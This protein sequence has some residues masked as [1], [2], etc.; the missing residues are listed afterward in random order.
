METLAET[1]LPAGLRRTEPSSL[2]PTSPD[3]EQSPQN[4]NPGSV[5]AN[6]IGTSPGGSSSAH[7]LLE[8]HSQSSQEDSGSVVSPVPHPEPEET[9]ENIEKELSE[10]CVDTDSQPPLELGHRK[11]TTATVS[12]RNAQQGAAASTSSPTTSATGGKGNDANGQSAV[13]AGMATAT[14][15]T[16]SSTSVSNGRSLPKVTPSGGKPM[17]MR[18]FDRK[19]NKARG[20]PK[21]KAM[22][23]LYQSEISENKI[24]IKLCIKKA[25]DATV[26]PKKPIRKRARKPKSLNEDSSDET[27]PEK[28]N[29]RSEKPR[30]TNNNT[31]KRSAEEEYK[32]PEDQSVWANEIPDP[33]LYTIF[34][35]VVQDEGSLPTLIRLS[36]VCSSWYK[37]SQ[38][39]SLWR[40]V[41]LGTWAKDRFKTEP[42]LK[43][44]IENRLKQA[45]EVGLANWKVTNVQ[46]VL[47]KLLEAAPGLISI[48]LTGWKALSADHLF[49]LVQNF[50]NLESLDLS[51]INA[52]VNANKTAVGQTSLCNAITEMGSRLTH[53][54]LAHNRLGGIPQIVKALSTHCPNLVLLDLSNVNTVAISHGI[55]HIEQLQHGCQKLKVL[56]ITNSHINLSTASLQEQ[57]E[58]PGFPELEELS[59]ASLAD[60]A[61]LFNDEFLQRI[62]K[63]STKLT[64]LDVRGCAR[65]THDSLIR[66]P[67]WDLKHLFLSGCSINRDMGAGL[68]LIASKW[69]HSLI[70]FDLAWASATKPLDDALKALADKGSESPLKY[71][72][73]CGS[74]VSLEAV[75]EVLANCPH[76]NA[77]N[78]ASCRGLPRGVKRLL[79][80]AQEIAELRE[81]LGVTLKG[82]PSQSSSSPRDT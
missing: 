80:G 12:P 41:D 10:S 71:L 37:M 6:I 63:T 49:F 11:R 2:I 33:V 20:R 79:Q 44:L 17:A 48:T 43:W 60:E 45:T 30:K 82:V 73:L 69:A 76:I 42:K 75:K 3:G 57:M 8:D 28:R 14:G 34:K 15:T 50:K 54:H 29:R 74:S 1:S 65:L 22:V 32:P 38:R 56:R 18:N 39:A 78:L 26:Q 68:E 51:S 66:L 23:A 46:C 72:N 64:L 77:I 55:L 58:S 21:R 59:V 31:E 19:M 61:R 52:E 35:N 27:S 9:I 36:R 53:L 16:S 67:T 5:L 40:T 47:D 25:S 13:A 24:G 81:N 4:S 7:N 70:E 62:L